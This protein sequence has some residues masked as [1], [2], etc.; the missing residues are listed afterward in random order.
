MTLTCDKPYGSNNY[1]KGIFINLVKIIAAEDVSGAQL[2]FLQQR[3]DIGVKLKLDI[4]RDFEPDLVIAGN[5]ERNSSTSEVT[6]WGGAFVVQDALYRLGYTGTLTPE[7]KIPKSVLDSL[8]GKQ[9]Y[10]LSFVTGVKESGKFRYAD[11]NMIASVQEGPQSLA[12]RFQKSLQRGYPRA[13]NPDC[14]DTEVSP[15]RD[16]GSAAD[17]DDVF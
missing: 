13:Y 3:V 16:N 14:M 2:P 8:V 9:F 10:R 5:F 15:T 7:N 6:G 4:G 17:L 1:G 12:K 11:W